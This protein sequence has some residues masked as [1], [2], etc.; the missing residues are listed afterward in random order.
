MI[1]EDGRVVSNS[2]I[3]DLGALRASAVS[4]DVAPLADYRALATAVAAE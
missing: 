3:G 4:Y 2:K 1:L